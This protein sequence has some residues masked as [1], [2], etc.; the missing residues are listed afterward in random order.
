MFIYFCSF[1]IWQTV[2]TSVSFSSCIYSVFNV[3]LHRMVPKLFERNS[4]DFIVVTVAFLTFKQSHFHSFLS[5]FFFF[6]FP[7]VCSQSQPLLTLVLDVYLQHRTT[8]IQCSYQHFT[9]GKYQNFFYIMSVMS[10][11]IMSIYAIIK[12]TL[13]AYLLTELRFL[14]IYQEFKP[15]WCLV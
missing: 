15:L 2:L 7:P 9:Y 11:F 10:L 4:L 13:C 5:F 12:T 6:D 1:D 14:C 8:P 3:H